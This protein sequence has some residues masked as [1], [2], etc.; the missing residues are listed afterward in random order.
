MPD[1]AQINYRINPGGNLQGDIHIPGDKSISHRAIML[2]AIAEGQTVIDGFLPGQDTLAT[3]SAFKTMGVDIETVKNNQ[4][5]INGA[6]MHGLSAPGAPLYLGNSGTSVRLLCGLLAGQG[7]DSE[8]LGDESLMKRPMQRIID[9]LSQMH[10]KVTGSATGTLPIK[11]TG[12][13]SLTGIQYKLPVASA[14]I[15]S[16]LLLA[17]LYARGKTSITEPMKT[18]DHTERM[19][20]HFGYAID[21][22]NNQINLEGGGKLIASDITIP[23]DISA[24]AFF[25]VGACIAEGSDI[26][27]QQVG[28][29]PTRNAIIE[30][31][32]AM[33]ADI[34]ITDRRE[35][36]GEPAGNI[37]VRY[38]QLHGIQ[39]PEPLVPVAIDEFPAIMIAAASA[40][41]DTILH[42]AAELRVK[43]SDRII[44][45]SN[46]LQKLGIKTEVFPDGMIV[47]G[48]KIQGGEVNS[49]GDHR[50]AMAFSM[51]GLVASEAITV[52]D[53]V[54]VNTSFPGFVALSKTA[55]LAIE[56][57]AIV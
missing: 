25:M 40:R 29:N 45:I 51:A 6:G 43:E 31:L 47:S 14:Q 34:E 57:R 37:R 18:R 5:K 2:A 27:L 8:L 26:T 12:G 36:S 44:S 7:F 50:I 3:M 42:N 22:G 46:G 53:C 48:G 19:L 30:I 32:Q 55:G 33:G 16:C 10:A 56:E 15:K 13:Q 38:S 17:G 28:L 54:N 41:G 11:I 52:S 39:I 35:L 23:G 1:T 21:C 24:A 20:Q 49:F 9:P 4:L